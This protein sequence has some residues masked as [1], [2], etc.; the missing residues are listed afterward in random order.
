MGARRRILVPG[1]TRK[2][3]TVKRVCRIALVAVVLGG[4]GRIARPKVEIV[5]PCHYIGTDAGKA[6]VGKQAVGAHEID[7]LMPFFIIVGAFV[8][9]PYQQT[10]LRDVAIVIGTRF[11]SVFQKEIL[12][13][14]KRNFH[15]SPPDK[16]LVYSHVSSRGIQRFN[17]NP[18]Q[19]CQGRAAKCVGTVFYSPSQCTQPHQPPLANPRRIFLWV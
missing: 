14:T 16:D 10:V 18:P 15:D 12:V 17:F 8:Y 3:H 6:A 11:A 13:A 7:L 5:A 2:A 9:V 1:K 19:L 4:I